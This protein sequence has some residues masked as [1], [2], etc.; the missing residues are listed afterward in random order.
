VTDRLS[1]YALDPPSRI[2]RFSEAACAETDTMPE[3]VEQVLANSGRPLQAALLE[4]MGRGFGRDFS[5]VRLHTGMAAAQSARDVNAHAYTVGNEIVFGAG[6]FSPDTHEGR[7]L[8]AHELTHVVQQPS[9]APNSEK[10]R[11]LRRQPDDSTIG[12]GPTIGNMPR[13]ATV[14][15]VRIKLKPIDGRWREVK[16]S[17]EG[18]NNVKWRRATGWYDFVLQDGEIWAVK[19]S[20]KLNVDPDARQPGHTEAAKGDRVTWG[21]QVR[22]SQSG[23]V[24]EWS[25]GTGHYLSASS[26]RQPV[27]AAGFPEDKF[28]QH[29]DVLANRKGPSP[30]VGPQLPVYQPPTRSRDGGPA[31]VP[32][33]PSRLDEL[34]TL[35]QKSGSK[36][37]AVTTATGSGSVASETSHAGVATLPPRITPA[38]TPRPLVSAKEI[39]AELNSNE[40]SARQMDFAINAVKFG[41][42]VW[43][44]YNTL[45]DVARAQN[46][47]A[48]TLAHS[49]PYWEA[50]K[51]ADDIASD[52]ERVSAYFQSL[53]LRE[54]L[55]AMQGQPEW[56]S[57]YQLQQMQLTYL[58]IE[59]QLYN[60]LKSVREVIA[61]IA[62]QI[63]ELQEN[64]NEKIIAATWLPITS[65]QLGEA[66][67]FADA[68]GKMNIS[69]AVA[70]IQYNAAQNALNFHLGMVRAAAKHIEMRLREIGS[71]GTVF[72]DVP[73]EKLKKYPLG[74]FSFRN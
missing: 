71:E 39:V 64:M 26:F 10:N 16:P 63:D 3:S 47:A 65:L 5:G 13:D 4:D 66:A 57:W 58:L 72:Y 54:E 44:A 20:A 67:L 38:S 48:S 11:V 61:K 28:R 32:A 12:P 56:D 22:F 41:L 46:M 36:P 18:R 49:S 60:S 52:A 24:A 17:M 34:E 69:L 1:G 7:L 42:G 74:K 53:D 50:I 15:A 31:K 68:G 30:G 33:G 70:K 14:P 19:S 59:Q 51:Q 43:N 73:T 62:D 8:L 23:H 37:P 29:P 2:Q 6:Q 21:G 55:W 9:S 27:V 45:M 40:Q 35:A 25:D